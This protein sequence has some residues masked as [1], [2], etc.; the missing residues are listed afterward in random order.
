MSEQ[1]GRLVKRGI[2]V[3]IAALV[4]LL[5][6]PLMA[7]VLI[8]VRVTM[9]PPALFKQVRLGYKGRMFTLLK[10]RTMTDDKDAAGRLLPDEARI[11][12]LG[13]F[14]RRTSLDELPE[15][16][17]VLR[18]EMSIVGPRPL[19]PEYREL[20]SEEQ[21]RRHDV[22]PG[23][24]G[25][26]LAEGRNGLP[27]PQKFEL[28]VW[29]VDNWSLRLDAQILIRTLWRVLHRKGISAEGHATM[30]QFEGNRDEEDS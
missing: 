5:S 29:Y 26:V 21:W 17:N 9:G 22:L 6:S 2:D 28:D 20:Y 1:L 25:L 16:V 23:I 10:F 11:T 24:A 8:L 13:L 7:L 18:G 12:P 14:L 15:L 27:W 3:I 19:L 4:L 30:P